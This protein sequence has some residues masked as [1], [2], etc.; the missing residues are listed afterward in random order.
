MLGASADGAFVDERR[1]IPPQDAATVTLLPQ[2]AAGS[3]G[4][5]T[6]PIRLWTVVVAGHAWCVYRIGS[7]R[8]VDRNRSPIVAQDSTALTGCPSGWFAYFGASEPDGWPLIRPLQG[9]SAGACRAS[10]SCLSIAVFRSE[11][12]PFSPHQTAET[13]ARKRMIEL[14]PAVPNRTLHGRF[15]V[16]NV[17]Q[18]VTQRAQK[19]GE[20]AAIDAD[21]NVFL[22]TFRTHRTLLPKPAAPPSPGF[23]GD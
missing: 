4:G 3:T 1:G 5:P 19:Q 7:W 13:H 21:P 20:S 22:T 14:V 16:K 2:A 11:S 10:F 23:A 15:S 8:A 17:G 9:A 12:V 6:Q 18:R